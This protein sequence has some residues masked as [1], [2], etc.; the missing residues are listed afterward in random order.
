MPFIRYALEG[1]IDGLEEQISLIKNQQ[2]HVHWINFIHDSFRGK[3]SK[4]DLRHKQLVLDLSAE[5][6]PVPPA[7]LRYVSPLLAEAYAGKTLKT[8][9]RDV[10]KLVKI[11]LV[12]KTSQG[13]R[14]KRE[15]MLAFLPGVRP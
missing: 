7:K 8:I 4:T 11:G 13:I 1:F 9:Q 5:K 2:L 14:A 10:E 6:E 3:N 12:E 15:L